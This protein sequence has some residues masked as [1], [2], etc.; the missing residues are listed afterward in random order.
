VV[1][2]S[3]VVLAFAGGGITSGSWPWLIAGFTLLATSLFLV[4]GVRSHLRS[5]VVFV[6]ALLAFSL[7]TGLS[8]IWS[9]DPHASLR[10]LERNTL[11]LA[12]FAAAF[13]FVRVGGEAA[14]AGGVALGAAAVAAYSLVELATRHSRSVI[15]EPVPS[16]PIGYA[17]GLAILCLLGAIAALSLAASARSPWVRLAWVSLLAVLVPTIVLTRS[18]GAVLVAVVVLG[19]AFSLRIGPTLAGRVRARVLVVGALIACGL[20]GVGVFVGRSHLT[21]NDRA[22]YWR[23]AAKDFRSHVVAGSGAGTY[24]LYWDRHPE[25]AQL[26]PLEAHSLYLETGAE[27]GAVGLAMLLAAIALPLGAVLR[28]DG[29]REVRRD[30][31]LLGA[32]CAYIAF[33]VHAALDWDWEIP[34][35]C[36]TGLYIAAAILGVGAA[37]DARLGEAVQAP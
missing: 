24:A 3:V 15:D 35:V 16:A 29:T 2:I 9:I 21:R 20:I 23:A 14:I 37:R 19:T 32:T 10:E 18:A 6:G 1:A 17:N 22:A 34:V 36:V 12:A 31:M 7:W 5:G 30:A 11:Y 26:I 4:G 13:G 33:V 27:L 28:R 25:R 8:A